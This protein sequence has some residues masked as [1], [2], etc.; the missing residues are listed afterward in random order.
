MKMK[1][2]ILILFLLISSFSF[3]QIKKGGYYVENHDLYHLTLKDS[4]IIY[5][6][7]DTT[8]NSH[9]DIYIDD[10]VIFFLEEDQIIAY[11]LSFVAET[12]DG[13]YYEYLLDFGREKLLIRKDK[14]HINILKDAGYS[15]MYETM[16]SAYPL[17][18]SKK[19]KKRIEN[20]LKISKKEE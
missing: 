9:V 12:D 2:L 4:S 14:D 15:G 11:F 16:I 10:Y 3:S 5:V 19:S 13:I 20:K 17:K 6:S 7:D 1:N 18:K 8:F